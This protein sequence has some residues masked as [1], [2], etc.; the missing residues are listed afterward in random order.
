M[1][2]SRWQLGLNPF[3]CGFCKGRLGIVTFASTYV[4]VNCQFLLLVA[5]QHQAH[6]QNCNMFLFGDFFKEIIRFLFCFVLFSD[7]NY[8]TANVYQ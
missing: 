6:S 7:L 2:L 3:P 8:G 5:S 4:V 1:D